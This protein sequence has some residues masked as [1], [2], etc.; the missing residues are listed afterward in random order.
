MQ[1]LVWRK[2]QGIV[3]LAGSDHSTAATLA[4]EV[5]VQGEIGQENILP[6]EAEKEFSVKTVK[7]PLTQRVDGRPDVKI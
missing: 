6:R 7:I 3:G 1:R 2:Q 4:R 5:E